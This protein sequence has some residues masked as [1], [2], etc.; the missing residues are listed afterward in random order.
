MICSK[1]R[2]FNKKM[3]QE[4]R[5]LAWEDAVA[6]YRYG[7]ECLFRYGLQ[8]QVPIVSYRY[9]LECLCRE[10]RFINYNLSV[11]RYGL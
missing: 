8:I 6:G 1:N 11:Y 7:L 9:W 5:N 3:Y 2:N 4:F 10:Y